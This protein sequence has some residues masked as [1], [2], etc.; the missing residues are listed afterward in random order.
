M[1]N[2]KSKSTLTD[3]ELVTHTN[4]IIDNA[5]IIYNNHLYKQVIGIPMGTNCAPHLANIFLHIYEKQYIGN[6]T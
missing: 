3:N 6:I 1:T 5:Y 2:N 4:K